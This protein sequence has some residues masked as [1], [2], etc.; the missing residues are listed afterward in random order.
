MRIDI[1]KFS[2][3]KYIAPSIG[4]AVSFFALML[5]L[6]TVEPVIAPVVSNFEVH[7]LYVKDNEATISGVM[8]RNRNCTFVSMSAYSRFIGNTPKKLIPYEFLELDATN[9]GTG[10]QAWGPWKMKMP[11]SP[12]T[13]SIELV[14]THRCHA[15]WDQTMVLTKFNLIGSVEIS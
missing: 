3:L 5:M 7:R 13:K 9:R 4:T 8:T 15:L 11:L 2:I 12:E 10:K 1:S 14:V 6:Y